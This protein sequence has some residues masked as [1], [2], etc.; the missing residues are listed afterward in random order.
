M[1]I[2]DITNDSVSVTGVDSVVVNGQVYTQTGTYTQ[3]LTNAAGCDSILTINAIITNTQGLNNEAISNINVY[4][5]PTRGSVRITGLENL[6]EVFDIR[7]VDNR[8][9]LIHKLDVK[10]T[11]VDLSSVTPGVY[12]LKISH[13]EGV[14]RIKL[15]K[16]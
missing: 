4:P 3:T 16:N 2:N 12:Y 13:A 5:N 9:R 6:S 15:V 11:E 1:I 14:G 7:I 10:E 8:G